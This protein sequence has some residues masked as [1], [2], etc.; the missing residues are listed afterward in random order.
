MPECDGGMRRNGEG[1][2]FGRRFC[3]SRQD[4]AWRPHAAQ[5]HIQTKPMGEGAQQFPTP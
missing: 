2:G 3:L 1:A 4:D 5:P